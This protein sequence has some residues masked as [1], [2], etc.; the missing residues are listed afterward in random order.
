[1]AKLKVSRRGH[2]ECIYTTK[3]YGMQSHVFE[4]NFYEAQKHDSD[5]ELMVLNTRVSN[6]SSGDTKEPSS[7][8]LPS[9]F[10]C[11]EFV[12]NTKY[13][14]SDKDAVCPSCVKEIILP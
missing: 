6:I 12:I 4:L 1:M 9:S 5:R 14:D 10:Q 7:I 11:R 3:L 2:D 13:P 8:H